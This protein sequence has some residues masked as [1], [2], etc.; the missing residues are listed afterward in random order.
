MLKI[1]KS[2]KTAGNNSDSNGITMKSTPYYRR[3]ASI[4]VLGGEGG[5]GGFGRREVRRLEVPETESGTGTAVF[6]EP[7]PEPEPS[8]PVKLY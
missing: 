7:K 5:W 6:Q 8:F 2:N 1:L 3:I 4:S